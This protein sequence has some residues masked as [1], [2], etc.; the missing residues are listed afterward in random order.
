MRINI[1][2]GM[3]PEWFEY[4]QVTIASVLTHSSQDD[5]YYFYI[6]ANRFE[7]D[8]IEAFN[9]LKK[10]RSI[11]IEFLKIDDTFFEG[12]IHDWL[13]VSSSYRLIL[14]SLV[15]ESKIL[16]LDSDIIARKDIAELYKT[17][18]SDYY[19]AAV[20]DKCSLM[21]KSRVNLA[22][23]ENFYNG[24]MQL[25]NLDKFREDDL[26]NV[27]MK[28]LRLSTFYT[29][30]DVINDV[31]RKNILSL[32]IKYN[33]MPV[34]NAY[35]NRREEFLNDLKDPV[36]VHFTTKPWKGVNNMYVNEWFHYKN[37][38]DRL[39]LLP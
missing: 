9:R 1:A 27:I 7:E 14:S 33:L 6:M 17:D 35:K 11:E 30:Q 23:H 8:D 22:P 31:C 10:M 19:L 29:D 25:I 37:I 24:G 12:A 38:V 16:Y 34:L 15:Q 20:E 2:L 5:E 4:A 3:T 13:G 39:Q 18:I 36:L 28:T 26:E 21:M 32:P